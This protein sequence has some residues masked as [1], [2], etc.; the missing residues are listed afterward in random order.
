MKFKLKNKPPIVEEE[1]L[2]KPEHKYEMFPDLLNNFTKR[3]QVTDKDISAMSYI[4]ARFM[5]MCAAGFDA[6][7]TYNDIANKLPDWARRPCLFHLAPRMGKPPYMKYTKKGEDKI[8]PKAEI[9]IQR[10]QETYKCRRHHAEEMYALLLKQNVKPGRFFGLD[11]E[12][13]AKKP[14]FGKKKCKA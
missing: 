9:I 6:A 14:K 3:R 11:D 1:P 4:M 13:E 8:S 2:D 5:S 7:A 12:R 10:I